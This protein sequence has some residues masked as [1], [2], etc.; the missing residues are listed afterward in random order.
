MG[1]NG[2]P[3]VRVQHLI[4]AGIVSAIVFF[5]VLLG[6]A[7][8]A[9]RNGGTLYLTASDVRSRMVTAGLAFGL[10]FFFQWAR[11]RGLDALEFLARV[12]GSVSGG[13]GKE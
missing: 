8:V 2:D 1:R 9:F 13:D 12:T 7:I 3:L 4:D 11:A 6:D 5:A 10:T